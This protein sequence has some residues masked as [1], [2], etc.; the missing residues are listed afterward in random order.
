MQPACLNC[1]WQI[2]VHTHTL[3]AYS[4]IDAFAVYDFHVEI[5]CNLLF[6]FKMFKYLCALIIYTI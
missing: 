2:H 1:S 4:H 6:H 3:L 5:A